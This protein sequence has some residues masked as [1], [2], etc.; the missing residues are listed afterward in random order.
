LNLKDASRQLLVEEKRTVS[1]FFNF[2][3]WWGEQKGKTSGHLE[4]QPDKE[5]GGNASGNA[6]IG[7]RP[8]GISK[9]PCLPSPAEVIH[10]TN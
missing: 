5:D 10:E 1:H 6:K 2:P 9:V 3:P 8:E 4:G 7:Q